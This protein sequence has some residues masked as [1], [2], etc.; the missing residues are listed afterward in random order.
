MYSRYKV[1]KDVIFDTVRGK[2]LKSS[3]DKDGYLRVNM[4]NDDGIRKR[5]GVHRFIA[6]ELLGL[7]INDTKTQ[8]DHINGI[9]DDNRVENLRLCSHIENNNYMTRR[10]HNLPKY[11]TK[12]RNSYQFTYKRKLIASSTDLD[13]LI[14]IKEEYLCISY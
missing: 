8:V 12:D 14:K 10:K 13:K 7:D 1:I 3:Y 4:W 11:I 9:K 5:V 2:Y 6:S